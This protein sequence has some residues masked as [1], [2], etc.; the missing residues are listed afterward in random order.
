VLRRL[1]LASVLIG[2][3][4]ASL[5]AAATAA[6]A[7][8]LVKCRDVP[9]ALCGSVTRP[10]DPARPAAGS[11][12]I[13]FELHSAGD[14]TRPVLGTIVA[15]EG[16]PGY[17][18]T[19][20][21]DY[22]LELFAPLLERRALLLVDNRGTGA[23]TAIDCPGLQSYEGD[24][25]HEVAACGAQLGGSSDVWGTA[26]AADDM[27]A[28]LDELA[29][30]EVDLYGDSYGTFF[31]QAF[32][33][34]HPERVRALVLDA[35]Y[36]VEDQDPWYRD[37]NRAMVDAFETM[38]AR[39]PGCAAI[40]G[41]IIG[42]I[43][44]LADALADTPVTGTAP[45]ADRVMHEVTVDPPL[46]SY[47][48]GVATYG[49]PVYRELDAAGRAWLEDGDPQ[50]LLR[51][52]AEQIYWGDA[53]PVEEFSE[54]LYVAVICND[55][56]QHWD[57]TAPREVR[58]DEYRQAVTDLKT[59][60][61]DAFAP[62]TVRE[63]LA[64]PWT[65]FRSCRGWRSPSNWVPPV[66]PGTAYPDVPTLVLVGDLD[67]ITSPEGAGIAAGRFP[68]ATFLEV[69]NAF[70]V[71]ALADYSRCASDIVVRFVRT[72]AAGNTS[73]ID[74]Y[75]EV[76]VL[77]QFPRRLG[78]VEPAPGTGPGRKGRVV[79]AAGHT[80]G[81]M[82]T[83]WW[84]M[85]GT[86]GAGLR[87]GRFKATGWDVARFELHRLRF[88]ENLWVSGA[89]RWD[90]RTGEIVARLEVG[91]KATGRLVLRWND[92]DPLAEATAT[93]RVDGKRVSWTFA[94]P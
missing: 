2:L 51:I 10:L 31:A 72:L 61:P 91:G 19:A 37:L 55:Y 3:P 21:R 87:G 25:N 22:Y 59:S 73:C 78:A 12:D 17:S 68:N 79:T 26:F 44:E 4:A 56:P 77:E 49:F 76:R 90:R 69:E 43:R 83:R 80:V 16:G 46:L 9:G 13:A 8:D 36:P 30:D 34:R 45:D 75:N 33:V 39:D 29:I 53:G 11:I 52:A 84:S 27:A 65:E 85:Y 38:C 89:A 15:V 7:G 20:S 92:W 54:G 48:M 40:D 6:P 67:S 86:K 66:A 88:V 71:T 82:L 64:S 70:H 35:A 18:T 58:F 41:D 63:W 81:D 14:T 32:A 47:L 28:V 42:R 94:A 50:P 57:I 74:D 1:L 24:Y 5:P 60:E 23:S 93:G 62:F